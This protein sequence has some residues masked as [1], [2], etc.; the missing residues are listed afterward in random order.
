M[1]IIDQHVHSEFSFDSIESIENYLKVSDSPIITTEHADFECFCMNGGDTAFDYDEY[2]EQ[3]EELNKR[4]DNRVLKGVELGYTERVKDRLLEFIDKREF[5]LILL[6]VHENDE[7]DYMD[8][9][10]RNSFREI[11]PGYY[12]NIIKSVVDFHHVVDV[13]AHMDFVLRNKEYEME[14]VFEQESLIKSALEI[15][16][17]YDLA[18]ELNTRGLYQFKNGRYYD[19]L[20]SLYKGLGGKR[21]SIGSDAHRIKD[22]KLNFDGAIKFV[23]DRGLDVS[24]IKF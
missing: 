11:L 9:M 22:F 19:Y 1:R 21:I 4:Y 23:E 16:I 14:D 3:V 12:E 7:V 6:S 17:K 15:I 8:S 5:D 10:D 2:A 13:V 18:L 20:F 24:N